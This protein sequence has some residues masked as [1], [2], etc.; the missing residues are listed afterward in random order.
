MTAPRL[1]WLASV[2]L[3]VPAAIANAVLDY[4]D[5]IDLAAA[6]GFALAGVGA[7]SAGAL[8]AERVPGN[9]VGWLLLG[10]GLAGGV[11]LACGVYADLSASTSLGPMPADE[12]MAWLGDWPGI[13]VYF[14]LTAF[15]VLLFPDGHFLTPRWR[16]AGWF[17]GAGV[18][19]A[20]VANALNPEPIG[21]GFANPVGVDADFVRAL[22]T[23]TDLLALPALL[24]AALGLAVR[25]RRSR[26][27]ERLQLKWFTYAAA[28]VGL[29]LGGTVLLSGIAADLA[30]VGGLFALAA[31][32]IAAAVA[33][34]KHRLYDI[35]LVIRR[36]LIYGALTATLGAAYLSL[37][38]LAGLA[39]GESDVAI[40]GSTL[41]VAALFRPAR[42]R[43]QAL[44]D[45]RF[46]R[47]RYDATRTLEAFGA[48]LRDELDLEAL[49][50]DLR[51]VVQDTVQPAHVSLWLQ[52]PAMNAPRLAWLAPVL[53]A[54]L[55]A[56][57]VALQVA[58]PADRLPPEDRFDLLDV[59]YA[60][61]FVGYAA[62]GAVIVARH[63][64]NAVGWLFCAIGVMLPMTGL[65]YA[66][67][68]YG[69]FADDLPGDE[70]VAWAFSW[71]ADTLLIL[72]VLMLLLF[73]TGR[74]L[75]RGWRRVGLCAVGLA[76]ASALATALDPGPLYNFE[77]VSNPL[78]VEPAAGLLDALTFLRST[79]SVFFVLGALSVAVR[80]RR[81]GAIERQQIKWL[82][83]ALAFAVLMVLSLAVLEATIETDRGL[84][85]VMTSM[86][87]LLALA[88]IPIAV[89]VAML[90]H[91]LY[92]IDVVINR[93]LV[94]GALTLTLGATYLSLVLLA[95]LAVGESDVAIAAS[96]L[97]VAALF[98]PARARIQALVDRRFYRRRYDAARTLEAFGTR[99][100][101]E[102]D[103]DTIA[104]DLRAAA[105]DS[106]QPAHVSLWLRP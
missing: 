95:G 100:R 23:V 79:V 81:A 61:G 28:I 106:L 58:T 63:P 39:V 22:T 15:L 40:A 91:R 41:A 88:P 6:A 30:F 80:F 31:L 54:V 83:A 51:G 11:T 35:D 97:A 52:E 84:G 5:L 33:V 65:L 89:G 87:A 53:S 34:L 90:R 103:L 38:L 32:P 12:W 37:V 57:A 4:T 50:A 93:T 98:R 45:H 94:Y 8:V 101:D 25:M 69:V 2:L 13:A 27:V 85:E 82:V 18:A 74:F 26:G 44:V 66:Y 99:L 14:G 59:L 21:A 36:T 92:D 3:V 72:I 62:V 86:I 1:L 104:A 77:Q 7:A 70:L 67:A 9:A 78:G 96:T 42:A 20:T 73:P 24:L 64:R 19:L 17:I 43:I 68:A 102:V 60:V 49:A 16:Y 10:I 46:Y 56:V 75:S 76:A 105:R 55:G 47:R 29:G 48:R 71:S